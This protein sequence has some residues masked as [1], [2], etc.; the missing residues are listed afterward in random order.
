MRGGDSG[1]DGSVLFPPEGSG[2][3]SPTHLEQPGETEVSHLAGEVI[4]H[5]HIPSSQVPV[6][7]TP[8]LQVAHALSHLAGEAQQERW[9][10][11]LALRACRERDSEAKARR[12]GLMGVLVP[13][14]G[15][16]CH[17]PHL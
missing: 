11:G 7:H 10:Q 1:A 14:H 12:V 13:A 3:Q 5:K 15:P 17:T 4:T 2:V 6:D 9:A 16:L 8:L